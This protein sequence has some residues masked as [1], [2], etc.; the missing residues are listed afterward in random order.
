MHAY[1][2]E[3]RVDPSPPNASRPM[4]EAAPVPIY[5]SIYLSIYLSIYPSISISI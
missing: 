4:A 2:D 3:P 1:I 5:I